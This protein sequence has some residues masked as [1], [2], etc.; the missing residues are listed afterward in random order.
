M[1]TERHCL[2]NKR[3]KGNKHY[4]RDWQQTVVPAAATQYPELFH[5][6]LDLL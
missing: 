6:V 3:N 5:Q 4:K 2:V 1:F